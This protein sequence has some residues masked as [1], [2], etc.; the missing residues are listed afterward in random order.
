M[1]YYNQKTKRKGDKKMFIL[2]YKDF[3]AVVD[4]YEEGY[5]VVAEQFIFYDAAEVF[6]EE[7]GED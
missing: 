2:F 7:V 5:R 6:F 4:S 1:L 3:D